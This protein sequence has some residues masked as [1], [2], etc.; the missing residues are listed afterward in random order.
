MLNEASDELEAIQGEDRLT[1]EMMV[2]RADLYRQAKHWDLLAAVAREL[3]HRS[4]DYEKGWIDWAY[5]LREMNQIA[6]AKAVLQEAQPIHGKKSAILHFNFGRCYC[7][8]GEMAEARE[9]VRTACLMDSQFKAK[10][11]DDPDLKALWG[12]VEP[13]T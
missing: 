6:E 12:D 9:R 7:R 3:T 8:L 13:T 11:L 1:Q 10:A 5:A 2:V 4:P